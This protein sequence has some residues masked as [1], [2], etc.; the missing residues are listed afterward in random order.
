ML[1]KPGAE[2][3]YK[4]ITTFAKS[5]GFDFVIGNPGA[6]SVPSYVG[7]VDVMLVYESA[8][9]PSAERMA[10]WHASY[11]KRNFG[12]IPHAVPYMSRSFVSTARKYAGYIYLQNDTMPDPWDTVPPFLAD[13]LSALA[14]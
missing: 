13:L 8:G 11:D 7:T 6:D 5:N 9:F 2:S 1:N 10:G 14:A 4:S 3:Y 12:I